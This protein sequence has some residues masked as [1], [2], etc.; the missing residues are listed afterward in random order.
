MQSDGRRAS[1]E[2][3]FTTFKGHPVG[4]GEE[5]KNVFTK[6]WFSKK[7]MLVAPTIV[8]FD[9]YQDW[10]VPWCQLVSEPGHCWLLR[11]S[12]MATKTPRCAI[13][14][15]VNRNCPEF[16][17]HPRQRGRANIAAVKRKEEQRRWNPQMFRSLHWWKEQTPGVAEVRWLR[18]IA[19]CDVLKGS[20]AQ[21]LRTYMGTRGLQETKRT[22]VWEKEQ[23]PERRAVKRATRR[24]KRMKN[25]VG[26]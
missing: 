3:S 17:N 9:S 1:L 5:K 18:K 8:V 12:R 11:V 15:P 21:T 22:L 4:K 26:M 25:W 23:K 13:T 14:P 10:M 2:W 19:N 24:N 16:D 6:C 20:Q 7:K